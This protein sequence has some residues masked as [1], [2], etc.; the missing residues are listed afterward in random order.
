MEMR[1][2]PPAFLLF[3]FAACLHTPVAQTPAAIGGNPLV[4]FQTSG[5]FAGINEVLTVFKDGKLELTDQ[6]R[7]N[8]KEGRI[9]LEQMAKLQKLLSRL[10]Y[11]NLQ[12]T[13][14]AQRGADYLTYTITT[15][16]GDGKARSVTATDLNMPDVL[17]QIIAELNAL[18]RQAI[19]PA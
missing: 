10:E 15:W 11:Q 18:R 7:S 4:V 8:H 16:D 14:M 19:P 1:L 3:I 9:R 13:D 12:Q 17:S 5:G 2:L 6:R